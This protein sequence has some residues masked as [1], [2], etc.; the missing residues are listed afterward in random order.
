MKNTLTAT[1]HFSFKGVNH[2]PSTSIELDRYLET[3]GT[4][5]DLYQLIARENDFDL[6]SYEYEIMQAQDISFSNSQ[7]LV[8]EFIKDGALNFTEFK[9]VFE[10]V[11]VLNQLQDLANEHMQIEDL[12]QQPD[13]K[14]ALLQAYAL[15]KNTR[16]QK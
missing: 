3:T 13:L 8:S 4:L 1:I 15:G 6:Y 10:K 12:A 9:S 7:G 5:P 14:E 16:N 11:K 2:S